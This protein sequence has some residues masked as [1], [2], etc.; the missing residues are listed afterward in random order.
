M[1]PWTKK[2]SFFSLDWFLV[3]SWKSNKHSCILH[4]SFCLCV[5]AFRKFGTFSQP[6][7]SCKCNHIW[8]VCASLLCKC[9]CSQCGASNGTFGTSDSDLR[10]KFRELP[11]QDF[12]DLAISVCR[13]TSV[14]MPRW[15]YPILEVPMSVSRLSAW[16]ILISPNWE[17]L[18]LTLT[19]M[20]FS[21]CQ[22]ASWSLILRDF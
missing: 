12:A 16:W 20:T 18:Y 13:N 6:Q 4:C 10:S 21:L 17:M 5:C 19:Y 3:F 8:A 15:C 7:R 22:L 14:N 9:G 1:Q 2:S 11:L